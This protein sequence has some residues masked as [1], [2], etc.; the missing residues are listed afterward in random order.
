MKSLN[1]TR[2]A[3]T[4]AALAVLAICIASTTGTG[5]SLSTTPREECRAD[6]DCYEAFGLGTVCSNDGYCAAR[7]TNARCARTFPE[8]LLDP[9]KGADYKDYVIFGNVAPYEFLLFEQIAES[10]LLAIMDAN[11]SG[12]IAAGRGFGMIM[13]DAAP[14]TAERFDDGLADTVAATDAVMRYLVDAWEV[15][16]VVGPIRSSETQ[17]GFDAVKDRDVLVV[18][19]SATNPVLRDADITTSPTDQRPGL[20]WRTISSTRGRRGRSSTTS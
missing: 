20:L 19:P 4:W 10:S 1:L 12:G 16:A 14:A 3:A 18:S 13:C 2:S 5:C 17:A 15:P 9:A 8:D 6:S 11:E 7:P